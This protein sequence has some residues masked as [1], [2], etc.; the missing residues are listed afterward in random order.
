MSDLISRQ[1]AITEI[2]QAYAD[3]EGGDDKCAVWKNVGLT[4]ALHIMQDLP[5]AQSNVH[6][7]PKDADC[8]SRAAA[9][10]VASGF[11]HPSNIAKE[12]ERLPSAEQII[13]CK[14]CK[15]KVIENDVWTCPF[16]LPG[17]PEFFCGYGAERRTDETD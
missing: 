2:Q 15:H 1:A 17:G 3:T 10:R 13:R 14:D 4:T 11:C 6:D 7:F 5:S 8:I 12:L 16:G 9:I